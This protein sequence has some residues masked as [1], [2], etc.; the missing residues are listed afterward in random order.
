MST[1]YLTISNRLKIKGKEFFLLRDLTHSSKNL[2]NSGLYT[3]RQHFFE[4]HEFLPYP[5]L[6]QSLKTSD[7]YK[8]NHSQA[9]QQ[10]LKKVEQDMFSFF[11]ALK[12][13]NSGEND[14]KVK[15]PR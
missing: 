14:R 3:L 2:Y 13:K 9:G 10:T 4:T 11:G 7:A 6:Y 1:N 5:K 12:A 15:L 8:E